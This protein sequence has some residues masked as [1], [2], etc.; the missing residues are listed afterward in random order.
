MGTVHPGDRHYRNQL[1]RLS[2]LAVT[3]D[4]IERVTFENCTLVGPSVI[5][6]LGESRIEGGSW[7]GAP[8]AF[9]W[10]IGDRRHVLGAIGL[11]SCSLIG[12]R[13]ERIGLAYPDDQS[14]MIRQAFMD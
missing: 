2:D 7:D 1:V 13:F 6:L 10:P 11:V 4:T 14:D 9:L 8:E 12:C 3:Q 5:A